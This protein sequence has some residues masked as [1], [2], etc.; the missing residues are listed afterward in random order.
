MNIINLKKEITASKIK[1]AEK[2]KLREIEEETPN[3]FVAFADEG[4]H[5]FD[6]KITLDKSDN[7]IENNCE[8]ETKTKGYCGHEIALMLHILQSKTTV[9]KKKTVKIKPPT[10]IEILL[11]NISEVELKDWLKLYLKQNKETFLDLK[12]YFSNDKKEYSIDEVQTLIVDAITS[13][14]GKRKKA[15][16]Q[17]N[18]KIAELLQK[19]LDPV[20]EFSKNNTLDRNGIAFYKAIHQLLFANY[21]NLLDSSTKYNKI[22]V[23]FLEKSTIYF[24]T[25]EE[26][27]SWKEKMEKYCNAIFNN[28]INYMDFN[29]VKSMY[30]NATR[31]QKEIIAKYI[32]EK[33]EK[34][35][36]TKQFNTDIKMFFL[37]M[38]LENQC[39]E[40]VIGFF[41]IEIYE[42]KYNVLFLNLLKTTDPQLA[43]DYCKKVIKHN[44]YDYY[45]E[46]YY[47]I[48]QEIIEE[49][50]SKEE[51]AKFKMFLLENGRKNYTDYAFIK[52]NIKDEKVFSDFRKKLIKT[53]NFYYGEEEHQEVFL[54]ILAD[55]KDYKT[56][57]S[58]ISQY[59]P[60]SVI[61][62]YCDELFA[63][64]KEKLI[65]ELKNKLSK[66]HNEIASEKSELQL[67]EWMFSKYDKSYFA[68]LK[69]MK[70][71]NKKN[72]IYIVNKI[73]LL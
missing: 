28:K 56:M 67:L 41:E 42:N 25:N 8:C 63:F 5:S 47:V 49:N 10:E 62:K 51:L 65:V 69:R 66:D 13:V 60:A 1:S 46:P 17:E 48:L 71:S 6:V 20:L 59:T 4:Q 7:V 3:S 29:I 45:N 37:E 24:N 57:I 40:S 35:S 15:S 61:L 73:S 64:N 12:L 43:A 58:R 33:I 72:E 22:I 52:E 16:A 2:V 50:G 38:F 68:S 14:I 34:L 19:S 36:S 32:V 44:Y 70:F 53:F 9:A 39:W 30:S 54:K 26:A 18:K 11:Q 23:D 55:E 27:K 21:Y 31:N